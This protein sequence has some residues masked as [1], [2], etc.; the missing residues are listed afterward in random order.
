MFRWELN[1]DLAL[2]KRALNRDYVRALLRSWRFR[3]HEMRLI[4]AIST[5]KSAILRRPSRIVLGV[6]MIGWKGQNIFIVA[7]SIIGFLFL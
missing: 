2:P 5:Q 6:D 7:S 3:N 1:H 4:M